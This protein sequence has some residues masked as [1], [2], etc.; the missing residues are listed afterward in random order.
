MRIAFFSDIHANMPAL[1]AAFARAERLGV[2]KHVIAGDIIGGG[3]HPLEV[4]RFLME[5]N[6]QSIRG[7]IERK[8]TGRAGKPVKKNFS[9]D[10]KGNLLWTAAQ[11]GSAEME[12][13][14]ALPAD[15]MLETGGVR[16]KVVHGSPRSDMD[17]IYPSVTKASLLAK[18]DLDL[19]DALVCGHSHIP[20]SRAVSGMYVVNCGSVGRPVDGDPA[21]SFA[22]I[23]LGESGKIG[24]RIV[25]FAYAVEELVKDLKRKEVP[26][27]VADEYRLGI[28]RKGA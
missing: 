6:V 13:L 27:A 10:K 9:S 21:G 3:P 26:G 22:V 18:L 28:K 1:S 15:L 23:E 20:F 4:T 16:I 12:W 5:K 8:V 19:P 2:S 25:R 17:Y 14:R 11:L 7:N 24:V